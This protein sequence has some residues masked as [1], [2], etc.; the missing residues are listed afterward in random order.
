VSISIDDGTIAFA[1]GTLML[2]VLQA[3]LFLIQI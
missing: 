3:T 1:L 2:P